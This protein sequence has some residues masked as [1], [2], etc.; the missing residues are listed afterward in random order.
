MLSLKKCSKVARRDRR[1]LGLLLESHKLGM[2]QLLGCA[3]PSTNGARQHARI[4]RVGCV[5]ACHFAPRYVARR[6]L[7]SCSFVW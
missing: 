3:G 7:L 5:S 6:F 4:I 1:G 2:I